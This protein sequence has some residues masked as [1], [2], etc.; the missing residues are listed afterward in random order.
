MYAMNIKIT[1][2]GNAPTGVFCYFT[3]FTFLIS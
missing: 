2:V 1:P 3:F